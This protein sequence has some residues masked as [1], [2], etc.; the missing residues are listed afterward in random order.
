MA[1]LLAAAPRPATAAPPALPGDDAG[2][3][4]EAAA[5]E[6][7]LNGVQ[8]FVARFSQ[9][10]ESPALPRPQVERGTVYLLRPGR[11]RWEYDEPKGKLAV[12]DGRRAFL[13]L[14]DER[15]VLAS[16][17]GPAATGRGIGLL[18]RHPI[19]IDREFA[20]AWAVLPGREG[21]R[22]RQLR[23]TP[24]TPAAEYDHLLI[25][26][27]RDHLPR[28]LTAV[29]PL[30]GRLTYRFTLIKTMAHLDPEL[31]RFDPPP[32]VEIIES[33]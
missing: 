13:Y 15:R 11:M 27:G 31:F 26:V 22:G 1:G 14:P 19:R 8:G 32:G 33:P 21:R 30:G 10:L 29:D 25:E 9:I 24:R 7:A 4:A 5:L 16:P 12:A 2:A 20:V 6:T 23:L 3:R 28:E 18:L 17:L